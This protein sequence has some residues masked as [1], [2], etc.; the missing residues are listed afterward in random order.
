MNELYRTLGISKQGVHQKLERR[1]R[2]KEEH[3][4]VLELVYEIRNNHPTMGLRD[5]Y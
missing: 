5:M 1:M 3:A 4:R 2:L